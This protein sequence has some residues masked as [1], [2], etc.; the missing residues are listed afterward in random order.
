MPFVFPEVWTDCSGIDAPLIALKHMGV[1]FRVLAGS[2]I[3]RPAARFW[4]H[5]YGKWGASFCDDLTTR[6]NAEALQQT[7]RPDLYVAGFPCPSFSSAG[8]GRGANCAEG[9][10]IASIIRFLR[11]ALPACFLLEN[12]CGLLHRHPEVLRWILT[13]LRSLGTKYLIDMRCM[14]S[15][16]H[17]IPHNRDRV[18]IVG[19]RQDKVQH[20]FKWPG[21]WGCIELS[22]FLDPIVARPSLADDDLP[23]RPG[24][25][26]NLLV[27][28]KEIAAQFK[29]NPLKKTFV[30]RIDNSLSW[31]PD[32][33]DGIVSCMTVR[34][35]QGQWLT[36]RGRRLACHEMARS[37]GAG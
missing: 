19:L 11:L 26:Q 1:N 36:D 35:Y 9:Q 20:P 15:K 6:N 12:V 30:V 16:D 29:C 18:W 31:G 37:L 8:L 34:N 32:W 21:R 4:H 25:K 27:A 17:G 22:H 10:V 33:T 28:L 7:G 14:N 13:Q 5:H 23:A 3:W 24:A 2:D